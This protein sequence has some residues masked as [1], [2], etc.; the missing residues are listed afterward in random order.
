[1]PRTLAFLFLTFVAG[2]STV[3][4]IPRVDRRPTAE[5]GLALQRYYDGRLV[6]V[7]DGYRQQQTLYQSDTLPLF[8]DAQG[9]TTSAAWA[10]EANS[11]AWTGNIAGLLILGAGIGITAYAPAGDPAKNAWWASLMPAG[12]I[13]W[14]YHWLGNGWFRQ[15]SVALF[16]KRLAEHVGLEV[17]PAPE[18]P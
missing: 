5:P 16:N 6:P 4:A 13:L 15:P 10:R 14:T 12:L 11:F 3:P 2:C 8:F 9:A 7:A 17:V 1:M 18:D